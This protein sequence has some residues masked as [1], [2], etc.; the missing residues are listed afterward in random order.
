MEI[1]DRYTLIFHIAVGSISL[2]LFWIP[3]FVKKGG[4][5]HNKV[6]IAYVYCMWM[7]IISSFILSFFN[8]M[9][10]YHIPAAFL[11]FL[12]VLTSQPLWYAV[13]ILKYKKETP[14]GMLQKKRYLSQFIFFSGL[15]LLIWGLILKLQGF[16]ILMVIFGLIGM[17]V[18]KDAFSNL[19]RIQENENWLLEHISGMITSGIAA[20]TAFFAFGGGTFLGKYLTGPLMAIPWILPTIIGIV[21]I[22]RMKKKY[23]KLDGAE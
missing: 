13:N 3:I 23:V 16:G 5:I 19:K 11:G 14:I 20:Y 18:Y 12:G 7:V 17:S 4:S 10:G 6:G 2:I 9:K 21:I 8:L 15:A 22:K 1:L